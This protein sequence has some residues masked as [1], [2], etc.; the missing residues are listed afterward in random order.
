MERLLMFQPATGPLFGLN[1]LKMP[2]VIAGPRSGQI[3]SDCGADVTKIGRPGE[4]GDGK[5]ATLPSVCEPTRNARGNLRYFPAANRKARSGTHNQTSH[6]FATAGILDT[7]MSSALEL[8][9]CTIGGAGVAFDR[10]VTLKAKVARGK[11]IAGT[12]LSRLS[13]GA[14]S[15]AER[16]AKPVCFLLSD[17]APLVSRQNISASGGMQMVY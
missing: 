12:Y 2:R 8:P 6:A 15:S 10:V 17:T 4:D 1:A 9:K 14:L 7:T 5:R 16:A 13:L 11:K 3:F